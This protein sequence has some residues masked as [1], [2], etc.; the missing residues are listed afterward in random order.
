MVKRFP[1]DT[2]LAEMLTFSDF[3]S[4]LLLLALDRLL[5]DGVFLFLKLDYRNKQGQIRLIQ[6]YQKCSSSL[7]FKP[8]I[9]CLQK[10]ISGLQQNIKS[11]K[12]LGF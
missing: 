3:S 6:K 7:N 2:T 9:F 10:E 8:K 1:V 11:S 5:G 4:R 12:I